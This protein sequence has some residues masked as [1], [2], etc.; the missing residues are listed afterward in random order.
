M[1]EHIAEV[2]VQR[3]SGAS[4]CDVIV[5]YRDQEMSIRCRD[6]KQAVQWAKIECRT[7]KVA[8]GF[9]VEP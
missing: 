8:N 6:Y 2:R 1:V 7:Y 4:E 5:I 3:Y 9:T